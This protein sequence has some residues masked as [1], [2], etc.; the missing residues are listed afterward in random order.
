MN[1]YDKAMTKKE[2]LKPAMQMVCIKH[3]SHILSVSVRS[4]ANMGYGGG[5]GSAAR[6]GE[7]DSEWDDFDE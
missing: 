1:K 7:N 6:A 4:N 5:S 2:Y 3:Q